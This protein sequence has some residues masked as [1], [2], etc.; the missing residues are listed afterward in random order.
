MI[1]KEGSKTF[2]KTTLKFGFD[3][4][5]ND[6]NWDRVCDKLIGLMRSSLKSENPSSPLRKS[7]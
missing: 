5:K 7:W 1:Y 6:N 3:K 2:F 4:Y